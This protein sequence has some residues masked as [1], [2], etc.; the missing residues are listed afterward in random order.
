MAG[1]HHRCQGHE[2]GQTLRD[3]ERQRGLECCSP[4]SCRV[5]HDWEPEQQ[6][7]KD[8]KKSGVSISTT[9]WV[10]DEGKRGGEGRKEWREGGKKGEGRRE[11]GK[12]GRK[13]KQ[14]LD[15]S[16]RIPRVGVCKVPTCSL[17]RLRMWL[18]P[19]PFHWLVSN[20][21]VYG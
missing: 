19:H 2:L 20:T 5:G 7:P 18:L 15:H 21:F 8:A 10:T 4:W 17:K 13:E 3:G 14:E 9:V 11:G 1:W 12:E 16:P 6:Q